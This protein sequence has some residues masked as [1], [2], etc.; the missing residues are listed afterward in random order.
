LL[1]SCA[2]KTFKFKNEIFIFQDLRLFFSVARIPLA[3]LI[4]FS[5]NARTKFHSLHVQERD[6]RRWG[7]VEWVKLQ[8]ETWEEG[9]D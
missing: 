3:F 4:E 6:E 9:N 7:N 2:E 5:F 1:L 8:S